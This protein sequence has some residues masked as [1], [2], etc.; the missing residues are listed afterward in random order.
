MKLREHPKLKGKWP[1][2]G[3]WGTT[4]APGTRSPRTPL[5]E[6]GILVGVR[7]VERGIS[8]PD[9][10]YLVLTIEYGGSHFS[11]D[12]KLDDPELLN[13]VYAALQ[14]NCI[15]KPLVEVGDCNLPDK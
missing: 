9:R 15:G 11:G 4:F 13:V 3:N 7:K 8:P 14:E 6:E 2:A 5:S 1:P 12:L 10:P